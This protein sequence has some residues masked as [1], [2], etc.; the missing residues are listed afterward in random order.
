MN[1]RARPQAAPAGPAPTTAWADGENRPRRFDILGIP[2][3]AATTAKAVSLIDGRFDGGARTGVAFLNAHGS[4]LAARDPAFAEAL[5]AMLVLNDGVGVDIAA[6]VLAGSRFPENLN[7]TD[8]VPAFLRGT[9]QAHRIFLLGG[10]PGVAER[11]RDALAAA[12]PRHAFVGVRHGYFAPSEADAV[13]AEIRASG[14]TLLLVALGNPAQEVWIGRNLEA[15]GARLAFGVGALFDFLAGEVSRAPA[16]IRRARLEWAWRLALE[17][18]RLFRRY[19]LGNPLFL[20]RVARAK[21]FGRPGK[22]SV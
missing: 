14:A 19:V 20:M 7:G 17:P 13:A 9:R 4:N 6:R 22:R 15:T 5:R 16:A 1:A 21:L 18:K 12:N 2:V 3:L 8:F 10:R 11:A